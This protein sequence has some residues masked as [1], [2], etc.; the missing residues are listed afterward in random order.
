[1]IEYKSCNG[2]ESISTFNFWYV[3]ERVEMISSV[4][5]SVFN[6]CL[7]SSIVKCSEKYYAPYTECHV[8]VT[9]LSLYGKMCNLVK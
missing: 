5:S 6:I 8:L 2:S 4:P 1:M 9:M 3:L 7:I